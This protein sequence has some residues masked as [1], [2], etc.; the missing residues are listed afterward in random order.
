MSVRTM[1]ALAL[2]LAVM[3]TVSGSVHAHPLGNFS[4]NHVTT[5]RISE[6]EVRV[7]YLLDQAEIPTLQERSLTPAELLERK[8]AE[9][10]RGLALTVDGK[11]V[12]LRPAGD[13]SAPSGRSADRT[14]RVSFPPGSGGLPTSRFE[15]RLTTPV[16]SPRTV[17]LRDRTFEDRIGWRAIVAAPGEGT[18]VRTSAPSGDPTNG[19]RRYP[20]DLLSSPLDRRDAVVGHDL[21]EIELRL[22]LRVEQIVHLLPGRP[23]GIGP[24]A[25]IQTG[26]SLPDQGPELARVGYA[27]GRSGGVVATENRQRLEA[28]GGSARRMHQTVLY[29]MLRGEKRDNLPWLEVAGQVSREM[30]Q[31]F[32]FG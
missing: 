3:A 29:R 2:T 26:D 5:V 4:V 8:R 32:F 7:R 19:L 27:A 9:V 6:D 28:V 18:A 24:S 10:L 15:F 21:R 30:S 23:V 11:R 14:A 13:E 16:D 17:R 22:E 20:E 31:V 12:P 25:E 1:F